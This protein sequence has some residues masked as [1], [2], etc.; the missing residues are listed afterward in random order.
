[1]K[2]KIIK[3]FFV[4]LAMLILLCA[5]PF[6][7]S[8]ER[9]ITEGMY[10]YYISQKG[11]CIITKGDP[12]LSG[13]LVI[14]DMLG[15]VP[16][17]EIG[18]SAFISND[19]ITSITFPETVTEIAG[20]AFAG[21]DG[22]TEIIIPD[23][24]T[25]L[26]DGA[27]ADCK[28][29]VSVSTGNGIT[30]IGTRTFHWCD[31]LKNVTIGNSVTVIGEE[32]FSQSKVLE[33]IV[34]P[35]NVTEI[36]P[37]SFY[38][39][40]VLSSVAIGKGL[41][42]I[43]Y[44][45]FW[46]CP[47]L[48]EVIIP[49]NV[50][51]IE[52]EAFK[53]SCAD[54]LI[55][56][57]GVRDIGD[58]F[59]SCD[60]LKAVAVDEEN[61]Y[62][63]ADSEGVLFGKDKSVLYCFPQAKNSESYVIPDGVKTIADKAFYELPKLKSVTMPDTVTEIGEDVFNDCINLENINISKNVVSIGKYAFRDCKKIKEAILPDTLKTMDTGA[64]YGCSSLKTV[65]FGNSLEA[66]PHSAFN[67]CRINSVIIPDSVKSI[68][69]YAFDGYINELVIGNSVEV[70]GGKSFYRCPITELIIPDSVKEIGWDA[71]MGCSSLTSLKLGKN[72]EVIGARAFKNS[73]IDTLIL[74]SSIK[75]IGE[76]AFELCD[77]FCYCGT[78]KEWAEVIIVGD[79][80]DNYTLKHN[81]TF[82]Y[83]P[84]DFGTVSVDDIALNYKSTAMLSPA[85]SI[86]PDY[87][88][89]LTYESSDPSVATVDENGNITA[90]K[91]GTATITCRA[92]DENGYSA[93]DT[94]TVTV[95][96]S[97]IQWIINILLL[98][99]LWY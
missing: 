9:E 82:N 54:K 74:P 75:K 60:T 67:G 50:E 30:E 14:P 5:L 65:A 59:V 39:S 83:A 48:D 20:S 86:S 33:S 24:V 19:N 72:V 4:S 76:N 69:N 2:N 68:G 66:I 88:Y 58:A 26:G 95:E 78:E 93:I 52:A 41:K 8:A 46:D 17:T 22:L 64:F 92:V 81:V 28:N 53:G 35:D 13:D 7:A 16:V 27:F 25:V 23:T 11:K 49:D 37:Y 61:P 99:F 96:Y 63:S 1:M 57:K 84:D 31:S 42:T 10:T 45:A 98:G 47:A 71:F 18:T 43:G 15:G 6:S 34:I 12:S 32:A 97:I 90:K 94:C 91:T 70:I 85:V 51:V 40:P 44:R 79:I 62:F 56:G 38:R 89:K 77:R 55:L 87:K 80:N 3:T 36:G 21:C 73:R 29:L